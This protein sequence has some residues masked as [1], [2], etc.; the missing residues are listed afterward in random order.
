MADTT[1]APGT[2]VASTWLNDVNRLT[3]DA[4]KPIGASLI[5]TNEGVTIQEALNRRLSIASMTGAIGTLAGRS[6]Y[7]TLPANFQYLAADT[8]DLYVRTGPSGTWSGP[9]PF[10]GGTVSV[11]VGNVFT[12]GPGSS[13]VVTNSGTPQDGWL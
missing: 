3:Y 10:G 8:G 13:V 6:V 1:F 7:N 4:P 11:N 9:F 2:L 5:G 12:G